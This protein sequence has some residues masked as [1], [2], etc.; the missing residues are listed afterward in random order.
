MSAHEQSDMKLHWPLL[1]SSAGM[2]EELLLLFP[3][4]Q[5]ETG[6][7]VSTEAQ[8]YAQ[9]SVRARVHMQARTRFKEPL[10][11]EAAYPQYKWPLLQILLK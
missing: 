3:S 10:A 8:T 5:V 2:E 9:V 7:G 6:C 1:A 4:P 11:V